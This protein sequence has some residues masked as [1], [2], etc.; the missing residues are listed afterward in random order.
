MLREKL[1]KNKDDKDI[2]KLASLEWNRMVIN[3]LEKKSK[4]DYGK[5]Y[6]N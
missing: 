3:Y 2:L 6:L 4:D 1:F 5:F